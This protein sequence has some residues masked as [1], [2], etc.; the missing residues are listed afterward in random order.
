MTQTLELHVS[1]GNR[2]VTR[3]YTGAPNQ[4]YVSKVFS[5]VP[6]GWYYGLLIDYVSDPY[7]FTT[8]I[9]A[10]CAWLSY[11]TEQKCST[12]ATHFYEG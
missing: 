9:L 6:R 12:P 1:N 3:S 7:G 10:D 8:S 11:P 5:F 4:L 2:S